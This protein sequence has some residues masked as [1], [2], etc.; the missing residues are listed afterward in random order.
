MELTKLQWTLIYVALEEYIDS[1]IH[2]DNIKI[3]WEILN[4][5]EKKI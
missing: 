2:P 5:L 1:D 4:K 3:C